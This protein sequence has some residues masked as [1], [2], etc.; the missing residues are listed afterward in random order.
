MDQARSDSA[1][2]PLTSLPPPKTASPPSRIQR[3]RRAFRDDSQACL[4]E[5]IFHGAVNVLTLAIAA[6]AIIA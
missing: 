3:L 5:F 1:S 6:A 2:S 4:V